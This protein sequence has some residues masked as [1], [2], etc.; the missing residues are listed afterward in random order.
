MTALEPQPP[1]GLLQIL[2]IVRAALAPYGD[3]VAEVDVGWRRGWSAWAIEVTPVNPEAAPLA[4][5]L[6]LYGSLSLG[7]ANSRMDFPWQD[8]LPERC[9]PIVENV[10]AGRV[11]VIGKRSNAFVRIG[12]EADAV[13]IGAQ[14]MPLPWG[15]GRVRR[16]GAYGEAATP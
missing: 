10:L 5:G 14:H 7:V 9:G 6:D 11:V 16:F 8:D 12:A 3:G 2:Q 13:L 1:P 4:I 15:A